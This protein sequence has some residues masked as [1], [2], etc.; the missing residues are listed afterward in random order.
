MIIRC[1]WALA[2]MYLSWLLNIHCDTVYCEVLY[3]EP[4]VIFFTMK[5]SGHLASLVLNVTL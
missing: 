2:I 5:Q 4:A 3:F 1:D